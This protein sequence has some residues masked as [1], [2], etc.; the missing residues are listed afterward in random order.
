MAEI[1][2]KGRK[3]DR[4]NSISDALLPHANISR[5]MRRSLRPKTMLSNQAVLAAQVFCVSTFSHST[6]IYSM[7]ASLESNEDTQP[8]YTQCTHP[9]NRM[10]I[11]LQ[12][13]PSMASKIARLDLIEF[14][15]RLVC[16][17]SFH[18]YLPRLQATVLMVHD[19]I[20]ME[21]ISYGL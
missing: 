1:E 8:R 3:R 21:K 19:E 12:T 6:S 18:L 14:D 15:R 4:A 2:K 10:K 9:W 20:W 11:C 13:I 7:Y 5:V 16:R 17:N